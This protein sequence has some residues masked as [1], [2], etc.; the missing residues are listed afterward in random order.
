[1]NENKTLTEKKIFYLFICMSYDHNQHQK[2]MNM[3]LW[4]FIIKI[5]YI[6]KFQG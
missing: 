2:T 4:Y 5:F 6:L 1:M 3:Q